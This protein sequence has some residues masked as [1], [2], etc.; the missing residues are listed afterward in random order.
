[1][2]YDVAHDLSMYEESQDNYITPTGPYKA[3]PILQREQKSQLHMTN[4]RVTYIL[5]DAGQV[6]SIH[7]DSH[8]HQIF[9][10]GHNLANVELNEVIK[11][12]LFAL[13]ER[14]ALDPRGKSFHAMYSMVLNSALAG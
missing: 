11:E 14:L 4:D 9:Y 3:P 1:M 8:R 12:Y 6:I 5:V 7:F 2:R 10:Q 13:Q